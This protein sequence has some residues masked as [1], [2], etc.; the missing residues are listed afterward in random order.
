MNIEKMT[1]KEIAK[2]LKELKEFH[3]WRVLSALFNKDKERAKEN[4]LKGEYS[5]IQERNRDKDKHLI[6]EKVVEAPDFYQKITE[7]E[8]VKNEND[9][10]F[11]TIEEI[12]KN[13]P[14]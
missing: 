8:G 7:L 6:L 10:F 4:L 1:A 12:R 9:P 2:A 13:K 14:M 3:G 5:T 11:K